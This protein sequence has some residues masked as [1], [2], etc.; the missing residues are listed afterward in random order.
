MLCAL[1]FTCGLDDNMSDRAQWH[2][3][4]DHL[5][6]H[7]RAKAR[8]EATAEALDEVDEKIQSEIH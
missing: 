2:I 8:A 5:K 7:A 3:E 1:F 4:L 6:A